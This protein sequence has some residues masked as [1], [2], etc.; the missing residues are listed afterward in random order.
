MAVLV[1]VTWFVVTLIADYAVKRR[2]SHTVEG[3]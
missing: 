3:A 1:T 2:E